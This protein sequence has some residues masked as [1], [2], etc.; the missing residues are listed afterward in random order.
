MRISRD[1]RL[2][3]NML[4][5]LIAIIMLVSILV[6]SSARASDAEYWP[7]SAWR[8]S[9]P[10]EQ[11]IDSA[12]LAKA[13][14]HV[15]DTELRLHSLLVIRNGY[16][17]A[18]AIFS[19]FNRDTKHDLASVSKPITATL[20]GAAI[21]ADHISGISQSLLEFYTDLTIANAD[22]RK[23]EIRLEHMLTMT[24][25]FTCISKPMELTL[26]EM[27]S[28]DDW[29]QFALDRPMAQE[30]GEAWN[31]DS[32]SIYILSDVIRR[33]TGK[34]ALDFGRS[35]LFEPLGVTDIVWSMDPMQI[36]NLGFGGIRM[37]P[38]D[39]AKIGML[40]LRGG[41]W[42]GKRILSE[43][44]CAMATSEL[45]HAEDGSGHGFL[46]DCDGSVIKKSGRGGQY[47][48]M[49]SDLDLIVVLTSGYTAFRHIVS[50]YILPACKSTGHL[51][52][53]PGKV[54]H[55]ASA[56]SRAENN[57]RTLSVEQQSVPALAEQIANKRYIFDQ[58]SF[59]LREMTLSF[60][61]QVTA[62]LSIDFMGYS[63]R[64][65]VGLDD[66]PRVSAG[67]YGIPAVAHGGWISED[68][69]QLTLDEVGNINYWKISFKFAGDGVQVSMVEKELGAP[70]EG[71]IT[72]RMTND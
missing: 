71:T 37:L 5:V 62:E 47:L 16:V 12:E 56:I 9:T 24:S 17:V 60:P 33:A 25:G 65:T 43:Q 68:T 52:P 36:N 61:N 44:W 23:R 64:Y 22:D 13:I 30:P 48:Y 59:W 67:Q 38:R 18:D 20:I 58:N 53:A 27:M 31:Y 28:S 57:I 8:T 34:Q 26:F 66:L 46:W 54:A 11:G 63:G 3:I 51:S 40:Y 32:S 55:L 10:E 50:D 41:V 15:I 6:A 72:G 35:A 1:C 42:D 69:F 19:P 39:L 70:P 7:T 21:S 14:D 49:D 4:Y 45:V 2:S 29:V